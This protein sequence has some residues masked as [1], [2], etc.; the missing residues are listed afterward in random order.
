MPDTSTHLSLPYIQPSQAQKHVTHNEAVQLLDALV[1][2]AVIDRSL[3]APPALPLD[4]DR[5]IVAV[6]ATGDWA[7]R[8]LNIVYRIGGAWL[9]LLPRTGWMVW[10]ANE[11][12]HLVWDGNSWE[13]AGVPQDFSD[14]A[15]R[16]VN[17]TD[18]T[19]RPNSI[20][21]A[22]PPGQPGHC[23]SPM[24]IRNCLGWQGCRH[25]PATSHFR[26]A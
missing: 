17:S 1:Q 4:G 16:L 13:A 15:F 8:D 22:L 24:S 9:R 6:G 7:G 14:T 18:P 11:A 19:K 12:R 21:L 5:Y 25:S 23:P 3:T 2:L 26:A 20:W 10:V